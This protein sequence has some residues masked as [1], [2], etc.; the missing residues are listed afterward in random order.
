M[1]ELLGT[2]QKHLLKLLLRNKSGMTVEALAQGL[3]ITRTAV[4]Q[5]LAVLEEEELVKKSESRQTGGRPEHLY[6]L[7]Q[8]GS[9]IFPRHYSWF[10]KMLLE[11]VLKEL[12]QTAT[13]ERLTAEGERV[14]RQLLG[15]ELENVPAELKLEKL[16]AVMEEFGYDLNPLI[17]DAG[18]RIPVI[19]ANNCVFHDLAKD[20]PQICSFDIALISTF[21]GCTVQH[22]S[23]MATGSHVCRF[24]LEEHK[25]E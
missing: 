17:W 24:R 18:K 13:S 20:N 23:C 21:S 16:T 10:A 11:I 12:G 15:N 25:A 8:K 5:H 9:E 22:E 4:R 6:V 3:A 7:T 19:E 2:R 1:I 14:A